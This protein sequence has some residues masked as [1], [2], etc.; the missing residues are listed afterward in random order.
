MDF[1]HV[2]V[3]VWC[4]DFCSK[5]AHGLHDQI[6]KKSLRFQEFFFHIGFGCPTSEGRSWAQISTSMHYSVGS[7]GNLVS[8]LGFPV[9]RKQH[10][11]WKMTSIHVYQKSALCFRVICTGLGILDQMQ[12]CLQNLNNTAGT[13]C[14]ART[15]G[16]WTTKPN[17][18]KKISKLDFF[19]FSRS[20]WAILLVVQKIPNIHS[21]MVRIYAGPRNPRVRQSLP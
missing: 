16:R 17:M 5:M 8:G 3:I 2:R 12:G 4:W 1:K 9:G 14:L 20:P 18:K 7:R 11:S 13:S 6:L 15:L 21:N 10:I 19:F